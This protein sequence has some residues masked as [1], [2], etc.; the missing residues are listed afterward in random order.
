MAGSPSP[1]TAKCR[2]RVA[3]LTG[4]RADDDPELLHAQSELEASKLADHIKKVLST[5]PPLSEEQRTRL[6]GLLKP[7][8]V[9]PDARKVAVANALETLDEEAAHAS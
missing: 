9:R 3:G 5:A 4:R 6:A 8:R 7:V 1:E 2:A